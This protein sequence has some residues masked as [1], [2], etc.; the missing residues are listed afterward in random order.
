MPPSEQFINFVRLYIFSAFNDWFDVFRKEVL[1]K[2]VAI[3]V[4]VVVVWFLGLVWPFRCT[5]PNKDLRRTMICRRSWIVIR[6]DE[7]C[8]RQPLCHASLSFFPLFPGASTPDQ[9]DVKRMGGSEE[10]SKEKERREPVVGLTDSCL[11][12]I[13]RAKKRYTRSID[14]FDSPS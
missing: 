7:R 6:I 12:R 8:C 11:R 2:L 9:N 13:R 10:K 14:G 3:Y 4:T 5:K 1:Q